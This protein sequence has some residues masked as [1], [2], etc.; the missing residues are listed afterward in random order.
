[1][2]IDAASRPSC[3]GDFSLLFPLQYSAACLCNCARNDLR[4]KPL[5]PETWPNWHGR[6]EDGVSTLVNHLGYKEEEYQ[7]GR[8]CVVAGRGGYRAEA[9]PYKRVYSSDFSFLK[10]ARNALRVL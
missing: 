1:M 5:C 3:R 4:Y 10:K 2:P 8:Y 9:I 6:L 7:L